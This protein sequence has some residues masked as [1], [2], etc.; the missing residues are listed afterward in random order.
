MDGKKSSSTKLNLGC[1]AK[2][3]EGFINVDFPGNWSGKKP[4]VEC[5]IS[6][7][8]FDSS[9]MDEVHAIHVLEHFYRSDAVD[10]L[11]EWARVLKKDG[12][13]VI[14]VP[15][16]DKVLYHFK[17]ENPHPQLTMWPLYSD[18]RPEVHKKDPNMLHKWCYCISE[19]EALFKE[20]GLD[21]VELLEPIYHVKERDMRITGRKI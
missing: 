6:K 19:L 8:P 20:V 18:P 11:K 15:C 9:S 14:E 3:W 2:L 10:V 5:D 21:N 16:L 1:G 7:L 17:A 13:M 4:D 12:L